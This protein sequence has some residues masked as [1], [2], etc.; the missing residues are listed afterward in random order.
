MVLGFLLSSFLA[1]RVEKLAVIIV[2]VLLISLAF[3]LFGPSEV[4]PFPEE[5]VWLRTLE[6]RLFLVVF[7]CVAYVNFVARLIPY[8]IEGAMEAL[9]CE[10]EAERKATLTRVTSLLSGLSGAAKG[11]GMVL[12]PVISAELYDRYGLS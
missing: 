11:I 4:L 1:K 6:L 5:S 3:I 12:A 9:A 8:M 10:D 2:A 7:L